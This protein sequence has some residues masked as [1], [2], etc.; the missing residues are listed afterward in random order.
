ML[1]NRARADGTTAGQAH[2][3]F[4][5]TGEGGAQHQNRGAHGFYQLIRG[6]GVV[7]GAA[8]DFKFVDVVG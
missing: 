7:D 8:V 6:N 2:L 5:E 3:R 1:V 4:A